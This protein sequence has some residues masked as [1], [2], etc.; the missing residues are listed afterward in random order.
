[1]HSIAAKRASARYR[2]PLFILLILATALPL[3]VYAQEPPAEPR[4]YQD[5]GYRDIV[6]FLESPDAQELPAAPETPVNAGAAD[7]IDW[8]EPRGLS[9]VD[10]VGAVPEEHLRG[11]ILVFTGGSGI[12]RYLEG[13]RDGN[14][15]TIKVDVSPRYPALSVP[16]TTLN[17]LGKRALYDE[18]PLTVPA[19]TMRIFQNGRDITAEVS[20]T[21]HYYRAGQVQP[22][23]DAGA[24]RY[25]DYETPFVSL[26]RTAD[27]ALKIPANMGCTIYIPGERSGLTA[28]FVFNAPQQIV[29]DVLGSQ[30]FTFHSYIG[31]GDSG[32]IA[33]L[34]SQMQSRFGSRHEKFPLQI[35]AGADY[36]WLH[37]P[38]T[39]VSAYSNPD[40]NIDKNIRLPGSGT[41]RL[42]SNG[43]LSV[44]H[45]ISQG[46]PLHAQWLD[47]D[48]GGGDY[49]HQLGPVNILAAPEYFVPAGV[50][51]HPC[52]KDGGCSSDLLDRIYKTPMQMTLYYYRVRRLAGSNLTSIPLRQVGRSWNAAAAAI[53]APQPEAEAADAGAADRTVAALLPLIMTSP[54]PKTLPDDA[55]RSKDPW[56]WFDADGRMLDVIPGF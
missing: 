19:S 27:G 23:H 22:S 35:P 34:V 5:T 17:C 36:V 20:P 54:A 11:S 49:L 1:M 38:P 42:S 40:A 28:E 55:P 2:I 51:Y 39:P 12:L 47:S 29:V 8:L 32:R 33:A 31:T 7:A 24:T 53:T 41:Y 14:R 48:M 26:E 13:R 52:M 25:K 6:S 43:G 21:F 50:P 15:V 10:L 18:W 45:T 16:Y 37:Y 30:T 44:D 3:P 9:I 4:E 46:L 56:G